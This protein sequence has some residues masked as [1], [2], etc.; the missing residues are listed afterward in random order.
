MLDR[1]CRCRLTSRH[2][3]VAA[4][5]LVLIFAPLNSLARQTDFTFLGVDTKDFHFD[6]VADFDDF[7]RILD[8]VIGQLG[9]VQ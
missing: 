8:L 5:S 2:L 3:F 7:F 6:F 9:N 4:T 1:C